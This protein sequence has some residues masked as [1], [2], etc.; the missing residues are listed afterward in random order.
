M[1]AL[2]GQAP[3]PARVADRIVSWLAERGV[4]RVYG[5]PGGAIGPI[6]DALADSEIDVIVCQ[7][8]AMA[9]Y[10]AA[11]EARATGRP[12]VVAVTSGPGVLNT[13][14]PVA[15]ALQDEVPLLILA[16]EVRTDWSGRGALQDGGTAGLDVL[17][18]FRS[19]V[20]FRGTL[21]QPERFEATLGHAYTAA[22]THPRGPA[23]LRLPVDVM[24]AVGPAV[25]DWRADTVGDGPDA[26]DLD[27]L[28]EVLRGAQR[29]LVLAG[30]G[31]RTAGVGPQLEQ[32]AMRLRAPIVTD[33]D[34]K[35]I[36]PEGRGQCLGL[37]GVGQP[38][39]VGRYLAQGEVD[40][41][42]SVGARMDDTSTTG[43]S[44]LRPSAH[45]VQL[46]HDPKR[47][48]RPWPA[49]L[50]ALGDLQTTLSLLIRSLPRLGARQLLERDAALQRARAAPCEEVDPVLAGAPHHPASVV[51]ALQAAF[52]PEAVFTSDIGNHLLF[53]ARHLVAGFPTSFQMS[54]GLGSMG[55][56]IGLA[57]GLAA[58]YGA[59][60]PVIGIC[61]DG[62][63][64]MVGNELATCA[65]YQIPVVLAV[66]DNASLGMVDH[67]MSHTFGRS[68]FCDVPE[69]DLVAYAR[70]LGAEAITVDS[71]GVLAGVA[72]HRPRGPLVLRFPIDAS[73]RAGNPRVH[74]FAMERRRHAR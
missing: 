74:G 15:A 55:S 54:N 32:L 73:I 52:G 22:L 53:A 46:D 70:S 37:V 12:G 27:R 58:A 23:L 10:L 45:H 64:L 13:L 72:S 30:V 16:G 29:P 28:V 57:M 60:R 51:R 67:G 56:G 36:V 26:A 31:A 66:F 6:Y 69:V 7:H 24:S 61:G 40:V 41:L 50:V 39:A 33:L 20:R 65:R 9:V 63:L 18:M 35:G 34:A 59:A 71:D 19:V 1:N 68:R 47:L 17:S 49:D 42:I 14:S 25:A 44:A 38:P 43:F 21:D 62:G 4:R 2:T 3:E 48:H 5:I 8:E 11:G